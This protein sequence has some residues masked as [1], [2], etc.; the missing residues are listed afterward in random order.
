MLRALGEKRQIY[1][2]DRQDWRHTNRRAA[3]G[4]RTCI[5]SV[6]A[7]R[8]YEEGHQT[9]RKRE[10]GRRDIDTRCKGPSYRRRDHDW[11]E[12]S[13]RSAKHSWR[14][15]SCRGRS[16]SSR[17]AR[18][19]RTASDERGGQ[20]TLG[21]KNLDCCT[22]AF[23]HGRNHERAVRRT[24]RPER[25]NGIALRQRIPINRKTQEMETTLSIPRELQ[26]TRSTLENGLKVLIREIPNAPVAGCWT[27]YR[28]G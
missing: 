20:T 25:K 24:F 27:I 22:E 5:H 26:V 8:L 10:N 16:R 15:R 23:R 18:G 21:H 7:S 19:R 2:R 6:Q 28:V 13:H 1:R 9:T 3:V 11:Q 4:L 17:Q 14:R 12:H